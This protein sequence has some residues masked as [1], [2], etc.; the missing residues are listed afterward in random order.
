MIILITL[1]LTFHYGLGQTW[2]ALKNAP[3]I[4]ARFDDIYFVNDTTGWAV[5]GNGYIHKTNAVNAFWTVQF[6]ANQ[7]LRSIE[8]ID[9]TTGFVGSVDSAVYMTTN[10]GKEWKRIDHQFPHGVPGVCGISHNGNSVLMV[11]AYYG[12][13]FTLRS[14]DRGVTWN[15]QDMSSYANAL[16]DAW[17]KTP[18]TVFISGKGLDD[19]GIVLRSGDGGITWDQVSPAGDTMPVCWAWKLHFPTPSVGYV[20]L[21][22]VNLSDVKL[23]NATHIL[24]STD[25]G[26]TWKVLNTN[27]GANIDLQ[28]LGFANANRGWIG[29]WSTGMYETNDGGAT[30]KKLN[31]FANLNRFFFLREDF[32]YLSGTTIF[33]YKKDVITG[34]SASPESKDFH[35]LEIFPNPARL[36]STARI[37][38][39]VHTMT[40]LMLCDVSGRTIR[41]I[42]RGYHEAG[43]Y[44]YPLS[45]KDLAAGEYMVVLLTHEHF[46]AKKLIKSGNQ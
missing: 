26:S 29:G 8:F 10:A 3:T 5:A 44:E 27:I 1:V 28:G 7:Y 46:L 22:E 33:Q 18:D 40:V 6:I 24:K 9:D 35:S 37:T 43:V 20:S 42:A 45:V 15:Y 30:W 39:G 41:E 4:K 11:G 36:E 16:V 21:E 12:S 19:R 23:G 38:L 17:Y 25:G 34:V 31:N 14:P 32:G 2:S 13:P